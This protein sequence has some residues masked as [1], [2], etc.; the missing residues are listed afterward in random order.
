MLVKPIFPF[1]EHSHYAL[2]L[3][4]IGIAV[5]VGSSHSTRLFITLNYY[6]Q[7]LMLPNLTLL[8][9]AILSTYV[10]FYS[11]KYI[12]IIAFL[13]LIISIG[14]IPIL[15]LD[16]LEFVEY[17]TSRLDV[18]ADSQNLTSLVYMQGWQD[19]WLGLRETNGFGLGF[20]MM[21]VNSPGPIGLKILALFGRLYNVTDGSFM[22]AKII[23]ELGIIG[24][25][26][27]ALFIYHAIKSMRLISRFD[28]FLVR[29]S[30][31]ADSRVQR[32][33]IYKAFIVAFSVELLLRGYGYFSPQL[34]ILFIVLLSARR[35]KL[36]YKSSTT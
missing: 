33:L 13:S 14:T 4:F 2:V 9:F 25:F 17:F 16:N 30:V 12:V 19:A 24:V 21:G 15:S 36:R 28:S 31:N 32:V 35:I 26:I 27:V 3:G 20:Q 10:F 22:A 34:F 5:G 1:S 23:A 18:R 11:K 6:F 7:A 29:P 8:V